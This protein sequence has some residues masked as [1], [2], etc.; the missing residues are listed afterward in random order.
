MSSE[1]MK[2]TQMLSDRRDEMRRWLSPH[3]RS[4]GWCGWCVYVAIVL[5]FLM[6]EIGGLALLRR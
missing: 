3:A 6:L 2:H 4:I 5:V 1:H